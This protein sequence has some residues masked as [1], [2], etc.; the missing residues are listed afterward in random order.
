M[1]T[2]EGKF[3]EGTK[4]LWCPVT[5]TS[6]RLLEIHASV[7]VKDNEGTSFV[8]EVKPLTADHLKALLERTKSMSDV[9][10]DLVR[11]AYLAQQAKVEEVKVDVSNQ[12][13]RS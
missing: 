4:K 8:T 5:D 10:A 13:E 6:G 12:E 1:Y 3:F 9:I 2:K 7:E 11:E